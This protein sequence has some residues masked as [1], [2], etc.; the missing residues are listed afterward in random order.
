MSLIL[1][2]PVPGNPLLTT[3]LSPVLVPS[4]YSG[5]RP[6]NVTPQWEL[7]PTSGTPPFVR[8]TGQNLLPSIGGGAVL[9][10]TLAEVQN[11]PVLVST[12]TPTL[13]PRLSAP[14][15]QRNLPPQCCFLAGSVLYQL[16]TEAWQA[17]E[18]VYSNVE[19]S[20]RSS[21]ENVALAN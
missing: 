14:A 21:P 8:I 6:V 9:P 15:A 5:T 12:W 17:V 18:A 13:S 16:C 11:L 2:H 20:L 7:S 3:G 10:E 4:P 1:C 19:P